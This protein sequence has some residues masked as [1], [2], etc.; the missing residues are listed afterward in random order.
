[1]SGSDNSTP[2]LG[3]RSGNNNFLIDGQPNK[4]TVNGGAASQFNQETIAEFQVLT[5]GFRAEFGQASGAIVNVITKSGGNEYHGLASIFFRNNI[6][7]SS[8][9]L[10]PARGL[11]RHFCNAGITASRWV[12]QS[13]RTK[14]FSSA[15]PRRIRENR[16]L[17]FV[18]PPGTPQIALDFEHAV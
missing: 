16:E 7:D 13:L 4:D 17:N 1:M 11:K 12:V 9:S 5:A 18:P 6:F 3:E 10:D 8:N 2:V 14:Y 15:Q